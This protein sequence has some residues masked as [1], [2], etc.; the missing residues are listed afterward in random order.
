MFSDSRNL[1]RFFADPPS[2][3][4]FSEIPHLIVQGLDVKASF[5][6]IPGEWFEELCYSA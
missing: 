2:E 1:W 5:P 3:F 4:L 6:I